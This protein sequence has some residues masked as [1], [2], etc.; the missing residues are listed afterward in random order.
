MSAELALRF[1][2]EMAQYRSSLYARALRMTHNR[3]DAEDLVQETLV[4]ACR[5][6]HR[7]SGDH[8]KAWGTPRLLRGPPTS[9][10]ASSTATSAA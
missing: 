9:T 6:F 8:A 3:E 2:R 5:A 1:D 4:R 10:R 7:F